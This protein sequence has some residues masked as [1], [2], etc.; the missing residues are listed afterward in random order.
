MYGIVSPWMVHYTILL[1]LGIQGFMQKFEKGWPVCWSAART[2][3]SM[4]STVGM[5][6]RRVVD[7]TAWKLQGPVSQCPKDNGLMWPRI[8]R[9]V[10]WVVG[11]RSGA[12]VEEGGERGKTGW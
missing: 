6:G 1:Y 9:V 2:C 8:D 3:M 12:C 7:A 5:P 10:F 4:S 11:D